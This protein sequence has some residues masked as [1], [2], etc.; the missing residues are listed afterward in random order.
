MTVD[1]AT[2]SIILTS[3][4]NPQ[5]ITNPVTLTATL[6]SSAG[7]PTGSVS[8][9]DDSTL[10]STVALTAG[11]ATYT[12]TSLAIG[13]HSITAVYS[14][15]ADFTTL[16]SSAVSQVIQDFNLSISTTSG[17]STTATAS[18][19]GTATY[20]LVFTPVDGATFPEVVHL[21]V[22]G[23]PTG[24]TVTPDTLPAGSGTTPVTLTVNLAGA[25]ANRG[26]PAGFPRGTLPLALGL[27][28]LPFA[29]KLRRTSRR[30]CRIDRWLGIALCATL[31]A[32]AFATMAGCGA[33]GRPATSA[34]HQ[35]PIP[36][37][38]QE[39]RG[40]CRTPPLSRLRSNNEK[41][42]E[43]DDE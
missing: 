35:P 41:G 29:A 16:T 1:K 13:T 21:T 23:L 18:P 39:L 40:R 22:S 15:D 14:G 3:S 42:M 24:A 28:L 33:A 26:N 38:S 11:V 4:A 34:R 17:G 19:G 37:P 25:A 10:L 27:I 9:Y 36:S 2:T 6:S 8:F 43:R 12:I 32:A 5:Y 31:S 30:L 20:P 7:V